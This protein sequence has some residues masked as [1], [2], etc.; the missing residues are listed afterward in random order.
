M[1]HGSHSGQRWIL[2]NDSLRVGGHIPW[3]NNN[4]G[5]MEWHGG[6]AANHGAIGSDG[7]F[8]IFPDYDTGRAALDASL[9]TPSRQE[10]SIEGL[11]GALAPPTEN[12]TAKYVKFVAKQTGLD[13]STTLDSLTDDQLCDLANAIERKEGKGEGDIYLNDGSGPDWVGDIFSAHGFPPPS[14]SA[15]P[16][17]AV[18]GEGKAGEWQS[19]QQKQ[20]WQKVGDWAADPQGC[21]ER[22]HDYS[23]ATCWCGCVGIHG[24]Q[25]R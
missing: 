6:F 7:R 19:Q 21:K 8:A 18:E 5:D 10:M 3:R 20:D 16:E 1:D 2:I 17:S 9:R 25:S 23:G 13:P 4:P 22:D 12:D 15:V 11:I 14:V 24:G